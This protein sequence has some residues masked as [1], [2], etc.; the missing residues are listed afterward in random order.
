MNCSKCGADISDSYQPDEPDVGI[1]GGWYC[2][3]CDLAIGDSEIDREP[4]D[5][6]FNI[7]LKDKN[8][9]LGTPMSQI[10][11]RPGHQG[12]EEFCRIAKSWGHE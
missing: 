9:P 4:L 3:V 8:I 12:F 6:D 5:G 11:G 2:H 10:S 7:P 1:S